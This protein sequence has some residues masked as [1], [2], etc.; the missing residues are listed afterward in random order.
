M[1][2]AWHDFY[3]L[4][5]AASATLVG[6]M[7]V[8][9]SVGA[10]VFTREKQ[11]A[12]RCFLSPTVVAFSV[13][14]ATSLVGVLPVSDWRVPSSLLGGM[15]LLGM[16]YSARVWHR[17][18]REGIARSIDL[19]DRIWYAAVPAVAY[20]VLAG[21][22]V[23]FGLETAEACSI[24]AGGMCLLLLAGV[25]NAWDMTTWVVLNRQK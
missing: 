10:G 23:A 1:L 24:L 7:F 15:G 5:G 8:A 25:R 21:A 20:L 9:A 18:V 4:I 6:L 2:G 13:V 14:L 3:E 19:E 11:V 12:L 22:G 16:L 17:L